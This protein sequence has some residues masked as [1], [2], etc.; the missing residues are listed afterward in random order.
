[1]SFKGLDPAEVGKAAGGL[2]ASAKGLDSVAQEVDRLIRVALQH[3]QGP[4]AQD[5]HRWWVSQH[6]PRLKA[7]AGGLHGGATNLRTQV[8]EQLQAS[9]NVHGGGGSVPTSRWIDPTDPKLSTG[10]KH[11]FVQGTQTTYSAAPGS[12]ETTDS[13]SVTGEASAGATKEGLYAGAGIAA[14]AVATS[15]T[16]KFGGPGGTKGEVGTETRIGADAS[17]KANLGPNGG[18]AKVQA[19]VG[20]SVGA[21]GNIGNDDV[22]V[23]GGAEVI[24]GAGV[25]VDAK[26][27]Y[28]DGK[29]K[30]GFKGGAALGI[31]AKLSGGVEVD[32][33]AVRRNAGGATRAI[34]RFFG[35]H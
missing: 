33:N 35:G 8:A 26:A 18:S 15:T 23:R 17:A 13:G 12:T 2:E 10:S 5:F 20:V 28:E 34:S 32:V 21:S 25:E 27:K 1:M 6:R 9:G 22:R 3:W 14:T 30:L 16:D 7:A 24:G 31:G 4:E 29:I 19:M 11:T